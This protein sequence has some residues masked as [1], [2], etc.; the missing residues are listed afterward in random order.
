MLKK[1]IAAMNPAERVAAVAAAAVLLLAVAGLVGQ[2]LLIRSQVVPTRGGTFTEGMVGQP[3]LVN[4]VL[5]KSEVD[6]ALVRLTFRNLSDLA[7]KVEALPDKSHRVWRIRLREGQVWQNGQKVISDDVVFTIQRIQDPAGGSPL[8]SSWQG[9]AVQRLS[10]LEIQF[11]LALP[12][13]FFPDT[14]R[15]L[16][17]IPKHIFADIPTENW[18]LS[19][20]LLE[21]VGN[22]PFQFDAYDKRPDGFITAY[23]LKASTRPS[24]PEPRLS[25]L[26]IRFS[27]NLEEVIRSWNTGR[28]DGWVSPE[29]DAYLA[30]KRPYLVHAFS[31][32]SYYAIF[33]NPSRNSIF[34][35]A[36]VRQALERAADREA[37][38]RDALGGQGGPVIGPIPPGAS[39]YQT[40]AGSTD[41]RNVSDLLAQ[42]GWTADTEKGG[43]SKIVGKTV[44]PLEFTLIVPRLSFLV[45]SAEELAEQWRAAGFKVNLDIQPPEEVTERAIKNRDYEAILFGNVLGPS[46]DLFSFWHSSERFYPGMN[47]ALYSDRQV[48][49]LIEAVRTSFNTEERA[50]KQADLQKLIAADHPV[51]FLYSLPLLYV[52][53][54]S[55][56]GIATST[57]FTPADRFDQVTDWYL[58]TKR[59]LK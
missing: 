52:T 13:A 31:L 10:E 32:P 49:N 15:D 4:P 6:R 21:P 7:E 1:I 23:Y 48:D 53:S 19:R 24:G 59:V 50:A 36:V 5:A 51:V 9:V 57:I 3:A 35:E 27:S 18:R 14:L 16:Y 33:L 34:K 55:I 37:L 41:G 26:T 44:T 40:A 39:Y 45:R 56:Q 2:Y 22:G 58:K 29:P 11:S 43:R 28:I 8:A 17:P 20:Y 47:L 30:S 46:S 25:A 38:I 54:R 12:Y 42:G